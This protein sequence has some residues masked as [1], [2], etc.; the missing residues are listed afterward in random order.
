MG[1]PEIITFSIYLLGMLTIGIIFYRIT[2]NLSDY[3]LGGRRLNGAVAALSACASDMSGWLLLGL[4][5]AVYLYGMNQIWIAIGLSTGAY[6]NW[7]FIAARLRNYTELSGDSITLP[8]YLENR[9]EDKFYNCNTNNTE[10]S[11]LEQLS[12]QPQLPEITMHIKY[13]YFPE[14]YDE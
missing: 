7:Q 9:F 4:P 11:C 2:G 12:L 3:I 13:F 1:G 10:L 8:D 5:G 14:L 6:I